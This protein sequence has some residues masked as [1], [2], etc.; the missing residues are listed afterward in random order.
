MGR[1]GVGQ[2]VRRVEDQRFLTGRGRYTDDVSRPNQ[3]HMAFVRSPH[4]HA[5]LGEIDADMAREAPGVLAVYTAAELQAAGIGDIPCLALP[6]GKGGKRP[7]SPGHP[8]LARGRVRHVGDPVA[9]VVAETR[10]AAAEAAEQVMVDYD[11]LPCVVDTAKATAHDAPQLWDAAPENRCFEWEQ[12]DAV[13]TDRAFA[14]A[15]HVTRLDL[16]NN[17]IVVGSME[18][19]AAVGEYE[20]ESGRFT[21]TTGSQGSHGLRDQLAEHI[22]KLPADRFHVITP[23]VGGGFGMKIFLYPEQVMALFAARDLGRPVK[24]AGE[25]GESFMSDTQGRDHVS[26]VELAMDAEGRFLGLRAHTTASMGAYLSNYSP[27]IPTDEHTKML[28]GLYRIPA[29]YASVTC[30]FTNTVSVDAYRGAGRPEAAY[31]MERVVDAAARDLGI[32]PS[33]LRRRNFI[34]PQDLPYTTPTGLTYDSGDF[35]QIMDEA[36]RRAGAETLDERKAEARRRGKLRG[37]GIATYVEACAGGGG[38]DARLR[39]REDGRLTLHVGT[40]TNGQG[41][42]TVY[43]Q[44]LADRFGLTPDDVEVRQGDSEE[45]PEGSGTSGSRSLLMGSGASNAAADK[46]IDK[47]KAVA[48]HLLEAAAADIEFDEGLFRVA[49]TDKEVSLREIAAASRRDDL[50]EQLRGGIEESG[51]YDNRAMTYPN[52]CHVCELEVDEATGYVEIIRHLVV[53]DFGT[54]VNPVLAAGQVHGGTAQGIGQALLEQTVY[55]ADTG[56][57]ITGSFMDYN[58]PRAD[59]VPPIEVSFVEDFPCTTNPM[60]IKGAGEAGAIGAPP[61]VINALVDALAPLGVR[62]IDMPATPQRVWQT[63]R[64]ASR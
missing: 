46:V 49:G 22:F 25:R 39:L 17:R 43:A 7:V 20:A 51:R 16:V 47:A 54:V 21:L 40:Q 27:F 30:V 56:Q 60:G 41:H 36:L 24:W 2:G 13:A 44:L 26:R 4:A 57:L 8:V 62:H 50:P 6:R 37:L 58:L 59:S 64:S 33:E 28:S 61:A 15:V 63:I 53:D 42:A 10:A 38:E 11:T 18:P 48:G 29:V 3:A 5:E 34:R 1:F 35:A 45:L 14:E 19:R 31:I 12:G 32:A 23:D 9:C 52:G 55:E